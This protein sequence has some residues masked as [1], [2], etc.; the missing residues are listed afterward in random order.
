MSCQLLCHPLACSYARYIRK[1]PETILGWI[2]TILTIC[3]IFALQSHYS[4]D[5]MD[6][7]ESRIDHFYTWCRTESCIRQ[8]RCDHWFLVTYDAQDLTRDNF[9]HCDFLCAKTNNSCAYVSEC[10]YECLMNL[11]KTSDGLMSL[12]AIS[13]MVS[14]VLSMLFLI[15]HT[16]DFF[17]FY[18]IECEKEKLKK[19]K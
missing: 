13:S 8:E 12:L 4:T 5:P 19:Y 17:D 7:E 2:M 11:A 10:S 6:A 9:A 3:V 15:G 14:S 1:H 16:Y 18:R